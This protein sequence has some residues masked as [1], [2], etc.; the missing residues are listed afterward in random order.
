MQNILIFQIGSQFVN[1]NLQREL[2]YEDV[3]NLTIAG[4]RILLGGNSRGDIMCPGLMDN[5]YPAVGPLPGE[6]F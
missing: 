4:C 2:Y 6:R 3:R 5:Y 1:G